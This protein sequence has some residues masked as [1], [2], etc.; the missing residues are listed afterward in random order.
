VPTL[1][2]FGDAAV[3][4][5][6]QQAQQIARLWNVPKEAIYGYFNETAHFPQTTDELAQWGN[7]PTKYG[8][9]RRDPATGAWH[10]IMPGVNPDPRLSALDRGG[11][12]HNITN[13]EDSQIQRF[14]QVD[15]GGSVFG[16]SW[17]Q[18]LNAQHPEWAG[19]TGIETLLGSGGGQPAP[20]GDAG[21][22]QQIQGGRSA[23]GFDPNNYVAP[24][25]PS[26]PSG[27]YVAVV[28]GQSNTFATQNQAENDFNARS[29][30]GSTQGAPPAGPGAGAPRRNRRTWAR[31]PS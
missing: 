26:N 1:N 25:D 24:V 18:A 16:G 5:V 11:F 13:A 19:K 22:K 31:A 4:R 21:L 10:P 20:T 12:A 14:Q 23:Q 6:E 8:V 15:Q 17:N 3:A 29:G 28:N 7:Q 30:G 9:S 27:P 2:D